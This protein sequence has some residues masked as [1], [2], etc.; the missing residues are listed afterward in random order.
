M[1]S[2]PS[3]EKKLVKTKKRVVFPTLTFEKDGFERGRM[4]DVVEY[5]LVG[6]EKEN[7]HPVASARAVF[8]N[9]L[10]VGSRIRDPG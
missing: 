9:I 10:V 5:K 3:L 6:D 8:S 7:S 4:E 1:R 2:R